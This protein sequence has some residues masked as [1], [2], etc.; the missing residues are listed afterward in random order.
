MI[1]LTIRHL[2]FDISY[3]PLT[4]HTDTIASPC[5]IRGSTLV[6]IREFHSVSVLRCGT[7]LYGTRAAAAARTG[8]YL[9]PPQSAMNMLDDVWP[10]DFGGPVQGKLSTSCITTSQRPAAFVTKTF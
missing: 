7:V 1:S 8:T 5:A 3:D 10:R 6:L 4:I 2:R 9:Y